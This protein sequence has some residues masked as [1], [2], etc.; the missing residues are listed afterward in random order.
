MIQRL[1]RYCAEN[2]LLV[3]LI[4]ILVS[5]VGLW[6]AVNTPVDAIPDLSD[7][8]VIIQTEYPGQGPQI[9]EDQVT[10]PL[11]TAMLSVPYAK[12]VRGYSMFGTSFVYVIFEDGTDLYWARSRVLEYL[13]YAAERLPRT[14]RPSIG[15]DATGVG[16]IFE[17][18]L[19]DSTGRHDLS[20][21]R[22]IQ[23]FFLRYELQSVEGVSEVASIG[24]FVKQYQVVV[25]PHKLA[26]FRISIADVRMALQ[27]SNEDVG[28]RLMEIGEREF[29]VR[30]K[31]YLTGL[32]DIRGVPLASRDG[33]PIRVGDVA[34]V[35]VG[36]ELRRGL[37]DRNGEGE[38]VGGIV[39]MRYGDN[40]R[41]VI[42]RV[43]ERLEQISVGLPEGVEIVT[44][45]DRSGLIERAVKTLRTKLVEEMLI[46]AVIV[47]IFL[48]HVRSAFV[49]LITIP[50]GILMSFAVMYVLDINAN[51]M[52]LGGIAIA[53][54]VM[55]DA[56]L[57]MVENGHKHIER[58]RSKLAR[59]LTSSERVSAVVEAAVEVGPSLF[60]SLLIVTISF[61]PVFTLEQVEGRLFRPLAFTK[62]FAM[63]AASL[64]AVTLVPAL[65]T[66]F[67]T[68]KIRSESENPISRFFLKVYRPIIRT[69]LRR[70]LTVFL[71]SAIIPLLSILPLQRMLFDDV[72]VPFP[73]LG[74]EF[75]PPLNEGDLLYMPTTLPGISIQKAKELLQQTDRII[76][77]FPEVK[78]VFG[79]VGRAES[80]T[81]P[82][83]LSMIETTIVLKPVAEWRPGMTIS[84]LIS[85]L[86]AAIQ[87]P[88]LTNA[89]T[90][91]IR[92]RTDMLATGIRTPVGIKIAGPNLT[93]L[94]NVGA[95]IEATL[96]SV[97]GTRSVFAERASGGYF[98]DIDVDRD[99]IARYGL[100]TGDVLDVVASAVGGMNVTR[101]VEQ[102]ERYPVNVRYPEAYRDN[103]AALRQL[104]VPVA[105]GR[106]L[107]LGQLASFAL[108]SGPP[109]IK[110]ENA[111]PNAWV[112]VD[113][114]ETVDIGSYVQ[115][116][117]A[118]VLDNV[119]V[120]AGYS[121]TW[122]GQ[123]EY[124]E[125]TMQRLQVL[126]PITLAVI[127]LLLFI[128]LR[129]AVDSFLLMLPLPFAAVGAVWIL[130][131]LDFNMS[132]AVGVG[133]I[134][135]A[136]LA[137]ETGL[138]MHVYLH[139]AVQRY[140]R[141]G[142]FTSRLA[143]NAALEE[144]AVDRVRPKLMT[145][146]TTI[147]GLLPVMFGTGIGTEVMKRI[148]SPMVGGLVTSMINTLIVIPAIYALVYRWRY[149]DELTG[150]DDA[151][152]GPSTGAELPI[153]HATI[154]TK[155]LSSE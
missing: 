94:E 31:G 37:V 54:G 14:V 1:I 111:R 93:T 60:F 51:I 67:V 44:E 59:E 95:E 108:T 88:G 115:R 56:S 62:T 12:T 11:S 10:Y 75:M 35:R 32:E 118:A 29:V 34:D 83:P 55:V 18:S 91:P 63:A 23:D 116:A 135:V 25:D 15:P 90:M 6:A 47:M 154:S 79:K 66:V 126:V 104:L 46:V 133:I 52:S 24:G 110:S 112:F 114:Q 19:S 82:A 27:R 81:D 58:R 2:R 117:R 100:T 130:I 41:R 120:P 22:S 85:E 136:G 39:V 147:L 152:R 73:Q 129:N 43:K 86:D 134:A 125:R 109:M 57:V 8:Q 92:A 113:L 64:L 42:A 61:L 3:V 28:G 146:F 33:T 16:W 97:P 142:R 72:Y 4:T 98:L 49:A 127:F 65:M 145:V 138:V 121:L 30:G 123:F 124:M 68:G 128:H 96:R 149:K 107:P 87:I 103:L 132:I 144:G 106:Q 17:Y 36:P 155:E 122:S 13:S 105:D 53:I 70:P 48:L 74:S 50:V 151:A 99:Q 139:E 76:A 69:T 140:R 38:T 7:V 102:L 9:V 131:L 71:V 137:A 89:W 26:A 150:G 143:L 45:Y 5:S 153:Q 80:A 141:E 148:A 20:E 21:L 119:Q 40:A 78:H 77:A 101:T 84:K